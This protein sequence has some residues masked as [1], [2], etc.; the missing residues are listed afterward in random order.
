MQETNK[1]TGT[2]L[3][4]HNVIRK[5]GVIYVLVHMCVCVCVY[6]YMR[7]KICRLTLHYYY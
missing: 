2:V 1:E 3:R 4:E 6:I 7:E 5:K